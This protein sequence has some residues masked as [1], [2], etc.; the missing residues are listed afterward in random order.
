MDRR[1]AIDAVHH[2]AARQHSG[3]ASHLDGRFSP[4]A[5]LPRNLGAARAIA[6]IARLLVVCR[7]ATE[8]QQVLLRTAK[9]AE[10]ELF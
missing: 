2:L 5:E 3:R 1:W 9:V 6:A 10:L 8:R 4:S 7:F